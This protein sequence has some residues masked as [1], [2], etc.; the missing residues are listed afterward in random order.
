M[1]LDLSFLMPRDTEMAEATRWARWAQRTPN[2]RV[3]NIPPR[4]EFGTWATL[5]EE[6]EITCM[7]VAEVWFHRTYSGSSNY[8]GPN[9]EEV[10]GTYH[11]FDGSPGWITFG[12][13]DPEWEREVARSRKLS[14]TT[15]PERLRVAQLIR[16]MRVTIHAS[17]GLGLESCRFGMITSHWDANLGPPSFSKAF[18]KTL[19]L[20]RASPGGR[21]PPGFGVDKVPWLH[22][23]DWERGSLDRG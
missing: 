11:R 17:A 19:E 9:L 7:I 14:R 5:A 6:H 1:R 2:T 3:L 13:Q 8:I 20:E 10:N 22:D 21:V 4:G 16:L 12:T 23:P 18:R 15:I